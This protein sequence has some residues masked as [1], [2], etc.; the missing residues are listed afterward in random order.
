MTREIS[1][2]VG[3]E[4]TDGGDVRWT[5]EQEKMK[6]NPPPLSMGEDATEADKE[7]FKMEVSEYAKRRNRLRSNLGKIYTLIL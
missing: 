7:I 3:E 2:Y 1:E 6:T 5:S 4:Y